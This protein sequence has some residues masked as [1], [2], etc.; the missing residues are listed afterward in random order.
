MVAR[1][2]DDRKLKVSVRLVELRSVL[3]GVPVVIH[4]VADGVA[5]LGLRVSGGAALHRVRNRVLWVRDRTG[6]RR[7]GRTTSW[8]QPRPGLTPRR[9]PRSR[10]TPSPW[11]PA[12]TA[13]CPRSVGAS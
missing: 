11:R 6:L 9:R 13:G 5:E 3:R 10:S 4:A 7:S 1:D 12:P 2:P 8:A